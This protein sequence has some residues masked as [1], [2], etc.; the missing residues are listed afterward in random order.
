MNFTKQK[1]ISRQFEKG[2]IS[3]DQ[4][5]RILSKSQMM[6]GNRWSVHSIALISVIYCN[7]LHCF[8]FCDLFAVFMLLI[9]FKGTSN[10]T[11]LSSLILAC[12]FKYCISMVSM[13]TFSKGLQSSAVSLYFMM[14][15]LMYCIY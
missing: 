9:P 7:D 1:P 14:L 5:G 13:V 3:W 10:G 2:K 6:L 15:L 8:Y 11:C 12:I 4:Y